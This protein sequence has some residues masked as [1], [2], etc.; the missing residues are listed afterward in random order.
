M[1]SSGP[2]LT[3]SVNKY[4]LSRRGRKLQISD[5]PRTLLA[6]PKDVPERTWAEIFQK[7]ENELVCLEIREELL[8]EALRIGYEHYMER[9]NSPFTVYCAAKA[10]LK[11]IDWYFYRHDPGE[12]PSASP[13]CYIPKRSESWIPDE[14]PDPS[15][16]DTWGRQ[17]LKMLEEC[18]VELVKKWGSTESIDMPV[19]A[20]IP[21]QYR[22]PGKVNLT[23]V[24]TTKSGAVRRHNMEMED[25]AQSSQQRDSWDDSQLS[26]SLSLF[27]LSHGGGDSEILDNVTNYEDLEITDS[28]L[29]HLGSK[30]SRHMR[31]DVELVSDHGEWKF[32]LYDYSSDGSSSAK[33]GDESEVLQKI[34]DY[35]Q[36]EVSSKIFKQG[37]KHSDLK[38]PT[39][40]DG[41]LQG[42][43]DSTV[44]GERLRKRSRFDKSKSTT[45][46]RGGLK[47]RGNLP[48]LEES[49]SRVSAISDCRL[50]NLRLDTQ[51]EVSPERMDTPVDKK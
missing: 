46:S 8:E 48:P 47:S 13:L 50:R 10:W 29:V 37:S 19:V 18:P 23:T 21:E 2:R 45:W 41:S 35:D 33:I 22:F 30:D 1:S 9:Q 26:L 25:G 31:P 32:M 27:G 24:Y 38:L 6:L 39:P 14:P 28:M 20:E 7:E 44:G 11:L 4:K 3:H 17:E 49:L 12:D 34:T 5:D 42:A 43:G 16:K 15:P 40:V 36:E 51:Y